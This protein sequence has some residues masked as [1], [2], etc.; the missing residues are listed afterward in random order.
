[1]AK[2]PLQQASPQVQAEATTARTA[3]DA[4]TL[5][6]L[7]TL[8]HMSA[9]Q[10]EGILAERGG[11]SPTPGGLL[12]T[13]EQRT[14]IIE[15]SDPAW[16]LTSDDVGGVPPVDGGPPPLDTTPVA[17]PVDTGEALHPLVDPELSL[18]HI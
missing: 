3:M 9:E 4:A 6:E 18:I 2:R 10:A 16:G 13:P 17:P 15:Q 11:P 5:R 1:M 12:G 7:V 14:A 8:G